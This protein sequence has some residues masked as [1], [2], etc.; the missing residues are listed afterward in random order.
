MPAAEAIRPSTA[1]SRIDRSVDPVLHLPYGI[2]REDTAVTSDEVPDSR[3]HQFF[4]FCRRRH[5]QDYLPNWITWA[6]VDAAVMTGK[7]ESSDDIAPR[8]VLESS[9]A[10]QG[11]WYRITEDDERRSRTCWRRA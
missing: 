10:W 8:D 11:C 5:P 9:T 7:V 2:P 1:R 4:A 6:D 3:T